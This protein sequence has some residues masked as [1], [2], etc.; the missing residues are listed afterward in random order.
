LKE[1]GNKFYKS[2]A[3]RCTINN[4]DKLLKIICLAILENKDD[5]NLMEKL[6]V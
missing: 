5:S 2:M 1:E 4:Y 3:H 6:A